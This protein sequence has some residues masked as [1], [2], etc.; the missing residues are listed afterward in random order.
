MLKDDFQELQRHI[1]PSDTL[2]EQT[3]AK[4]QQALL[5]RKHKEKKFKQTV[6]I[7]YRTAA[8]AACILF[9]TIIG[10]YFNQVNNVSKGMSA[11]TAM[12]NSSPKEAVTSQFDSSPENLLPNEQTT[13]VIV[14]ENA[15]K[16][17]ADATQQSNNMKSSSIYK[18]SSKMENG[19]S[20]SNPDQEKNLQTVLPVTSDIILSHL[21]PGEHVNSVRLNNGSLNFI[22]PEYAY[23][24]LRFHFVPSKSV[25]WTQEEYFH[26]LECNPLPMEIPSDL[27]LLYLNSDSKIRVTV[28]SDGTVSNDKVTFTYGLANA[29]NSKNVLDRQLKITTAKGTIPNSDII[30]FFDKENASKIKEITVNVGYQPK[31]IND[32]KIDVYCAQFMYNNVGY[33]IE[34][35]CLTQEEFIKVLLSIIK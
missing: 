12:D 16:E 28:N 30:F 6:K 26:Y 25:T 27:A 19:A 35:Q 34:S 10:F 21:T 3:K 29:E 20:V 15:K 23:R 14:S 7:I 17:S 22:T 11:T 2:I 8:T 1:Q 32:Q 24:P 18:T 5:E 4:M 9:V 13:S 33:Y 31:E